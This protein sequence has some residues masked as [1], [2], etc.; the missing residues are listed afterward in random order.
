MKMENIWDEGKF[1]ML[2]RS[3][4]KRLKKLYICEQTQSSSL[5]LKSLPANG[6]RMPPPPHPHHHLYVSLGVRTMSPEDLYNG[7]RFWTLDS[8]INKQS[9]GI[10]HL[11]LFKRYFKSERFIKV[12]IQRSLFHWCF[13]L[14]PLLLIQNQLNFH[15]RVYRTKKQNY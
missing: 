7:S 4:S 9:L 10:T 3:L 8:S 6:F 11:N 2:L 5:E 15:I 14:L 12:W 1:S 13:P